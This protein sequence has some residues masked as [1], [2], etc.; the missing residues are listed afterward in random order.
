VHGA[1]KLD[2]YQVLVI[3]TNKEYVIKVEFAFNFERK[4][5]MKINSREERQKILEDYIG[6]KIGA[7]AVVTYN[8]HTESIWFANMGKS[9]SEDGSTW[10]LEAPNQL[11]TYNI[12]NNK[13]KRYY[14]RQGLVI[15]G[16]KAYEINSWQTAPFLP[17]V[18]DDLTFITEDE[19]VDYLLSMNS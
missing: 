9:F 4:S 5:V 1:I 7:Y 2:R 8:D 16:N 10:F 17:D 18:I 6:E 14:H 3:E 12:E 19:C 13:D 15:R 11:Y